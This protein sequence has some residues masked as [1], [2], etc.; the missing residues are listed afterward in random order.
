MIASPVDD[1]RRVWWVRDEDGEST[2]TQAKSVAVVEGKV[3]VDLGSHHEEFV[4]L[5]EI[6]VEPGTTKMM[7]NQVEVKIPIGVG[8][9]RGYET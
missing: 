7:F 3:R 1:E 2:V 4:V 5:G 8:K 9:G 6:P